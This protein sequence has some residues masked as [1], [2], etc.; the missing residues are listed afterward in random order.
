MPRRHTELR[1]SSCFPLHKPRAST[2]IALHRLANPSPTEVSIIA[3]LEVPHTHHFSEDSLFTVCSPKGMQ[4]TD[5]NLTW[6][7]TGRTKMSG[8]KILCVEDQ[9]ED[10]AI[11]TAALEGIG[12]EVMPASNGGQ[13]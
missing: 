11:L 10:M 9:A 1:G 6:I 2:T 3:F 13:A 8:M 4:E 7:F 12:Y 5:P